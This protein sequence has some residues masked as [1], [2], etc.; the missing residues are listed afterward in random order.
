MAKMTSEEYGNSL[1]AIYAT[2][3]GNRLSPREIIQ[4]EFILSM[5]YKLG[6]DFDPEKRALLFHSHQTCQEVLAKYNR[7]FLSMMFA[8]KRHAKRVNDLMHRL[9]VVF[10]TILTPEEFKAFTGL[11]SPDDCGNVV[12]ADLIPEH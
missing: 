3:P 2:N 8:P 10:S 4:A 9:L 12:D 7:K 11:S 6:R 5:D 1:R